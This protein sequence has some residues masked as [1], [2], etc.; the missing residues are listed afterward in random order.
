MNPA[1][2]QGR[3]GDD[4]DHRCLTVPGDH[5]RLFVVA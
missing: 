4:D 1:H 3:R 5:D 2:G